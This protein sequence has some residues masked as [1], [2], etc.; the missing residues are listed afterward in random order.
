V[1]S[2]PNQ[3]GST[4]KAQSPKPFK[5]SK[6]PASEASMSLAF[7]RFGYPDIP[8]KSPFVSPLL[9]LVIS[10]LRQL[11]TQ[12]VL[13]R[14]AIIHKY[15]ANSLSLDSPEMERIKFACKEA[16]VF[17]I[18]GYSERDGGSLYMAQ[19]YISEEG[20]IVNHRR[21]IKPTH[22][23]RSLWGDSTASSLKN[24][25]KSKY[26]K[27]G[28]LCCFEHYQPL[29]RYYE[30]TQ[31]VQIHVAAWPPFFEYKEPN[32][33]QGTST[34]SQ[35]ASQFFALEGQ[36]FVLVSTQIVT[37]DN[38]K[39]MDLEKEGVTKVSAALNRCSSAEKDVLTCG[40]AG[41]GFAM[42]F[43]PD[44]RP[45]V[46]A[47]PADQ[48]GILHTDIDLGDIDY[49]KNLLDPVGQYSRPDMLS[50]LVNTREGKHV[51]ETL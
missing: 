24:V 7:L 42:I 31:G 44:G 40:Q 23:E 19:T 39:L 38:L 51:I 1:L 28:A 21:K 26:G 41:G 22:V 49:S 20:D 9:H 14:G 13:E 25:V 43:G 34:A 50:L 30:Y 4:F 45:L 46:E 12:S 11:W 17:V 5:S 6:M 33:F 10:S 2:K 32:A 37:G 18:L 48:E 47:L 3:Y 29:L 35:L 15:M 16:H 27:I 36:A 8:G